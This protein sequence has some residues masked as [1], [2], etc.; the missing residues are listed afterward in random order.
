MGATGARALI[1]AM[2]VVLPFVSGCSGNAD[3]N[4]GGGSG[5]IVIG[6]NADPGNLDPQATVN[7]ANLV[8]GVLAYDTPVTLLDGGE[9]VP[10][11]VTDW[12]RDGNTWTLTVKNGVTCSDGTPVNGKTLADNINYVTNPDNGSAMNGVAVPSGAT[13][14]SDRLTTT[15]QL[16]G[17]A[18]FFMENLAQLPIVCG[19]GLTDRSILKDHSSGSGPY[20]LK[21]VKAGQEYTYTQREDYA[22]GPEGKT[23]ADTNI[24]SQITVQVVRD[25]TTLATLMQSGDVDVAKLVGT[26]AERL[27]HAGLDSAEKLAINSELA[28]NHQSPGLNE[29]EVR[30]ALIAAV[31]KETLA[32]IDTAG[33]GT[34]ANGLL[35]DPKI[36]PGDTVTGVSPDYDP[37]AAAQMLDDAG[38]VTGSDGIRAKDGQKLSVSV[39]FNNAIT[40]N[41]PAVEYLTQQWQDLGVDARADGMTVDQ[42]N[43]IVFSREGGTWDGWYSALGVS[44]PAT[45]VPF[46]QGETTP[47]GLNFASIDNPDY[48]S[49]IKQANKQ[50]GAAGCDAWNKGEMALIRDADF[51]PLTTIAAKYF[52]GDKVKVELAN[53]LLL[54]MYITMTS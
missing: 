48:N 24:A 23:A 4:S 25:A 46:F 40:T 39:V 5:D 16:S 44:N 12:S 30:R 18:P 21:T 29:P 31:D 3:G 38:W 42:M 20:V 6:V 53:G 41:A 26:D 49:A 10:Q 52:F 50:D 17:R 45:L 32:K 8:M 35:A 34:I 14:T 36:C 13:A 28:F 37:D 1:M 15:V 2:A 11:V 19:R 9:V 43:G 51:T 33:A 22:W 27:V 47:N 7:D 54:P